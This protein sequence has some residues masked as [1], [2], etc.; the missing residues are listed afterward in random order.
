[1]SSKMSINDLVCEIDRCAKMLNQLGMSI[2]ETRDE[3]TYAEGEMVVTI[4][5]KLGQLRENIV[6]SEIVA[7]DSEKEGG[8]HE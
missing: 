4:A 8:C 7:N 1:M 3:Q 5:E 6:E 2:A